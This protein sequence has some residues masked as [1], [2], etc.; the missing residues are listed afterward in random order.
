LKHAAKI[1]R[2]K[3]SWCDNFC[4][5]VFEKLFSF[6]HATERSEA[7]ATCKE[8]PAIPVNKVVDIKTIL[9]RKEGQGGRKPQGVA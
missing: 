8:M 4:G 7:T 5:C 1:I 3:K 2:F 9:E 6:C